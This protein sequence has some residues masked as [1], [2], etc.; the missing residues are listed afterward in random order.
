M[1]KLGISILLAGLMSLTSYADELQLQQD[2]PDRYTVV[3][4]DTLWD[5]SGKFLKDPWKWPQIWGMNKAE[6][7]NP[8]WIYPGDIVILD[9]SG[10]DPKLSLQRSA[11]PRT[12]K[13]SPQVRGT[14][15]DE[16]GILPIPASSINAFLKQPFVMGEGALDKAPRIL[17][18]QEDRMMLGAGDLAYATNDG[19]GTLNWKILRPG[20]A[21]IDP[22]SKEVLGYEV[23]YL[24][25]ARTQVQG[26]PQ[27]VLITSTAQE[28]QA[29]DRLI[30]DEDNYSFRYVP[31][32]AS[33]D[34]QGKVVAVYG[35][36]SEA[37]QFSTI[38][39]NKGTRDGIDE[40]T[41]FAVY[42]N[43]GKVDDINLPNARSGLVMVYRVFDK[44][45]YALVMQAKRPL[46]K[47][48]IVRNP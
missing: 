17:A 29:K 13:L 33:A 26:Q 4:G 8:H 14:A 2:A 25:E 32:A 41:V 20:K 11:A 39:L 16:I 28:V 15:I 44:V 9:R 47:L 23:T 19:S 48:D 5:I 10:K 24:G 34:V 31:H 38:I 42:K 12:V 18:A 46:N 3:K 45:A 36:L 40:G 7:K 1:Y 27:R 43:A 30:A 35:G 37:G 6:I 21:L 22:D